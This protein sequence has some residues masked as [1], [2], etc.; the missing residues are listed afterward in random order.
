VADLERRGYRSAMRAVDL[1]D[2]GRWY[3]VYVGSYADRGEA[4]AARPELLEQ[5]DIDWA[6]PSRF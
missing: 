5:L 4:L 2:R 3:R 1:P 6:M